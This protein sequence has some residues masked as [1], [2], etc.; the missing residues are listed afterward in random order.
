MTSIKQQSEKL[1]DISHTWE[2]E[3]HIQQGG[4]K[5]YKKLVKPMKKSTYTGLYGEA[6]GGKC[7]CAGA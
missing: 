3:K 1:D 4:E 5:M 7:N 2:Y 6:H